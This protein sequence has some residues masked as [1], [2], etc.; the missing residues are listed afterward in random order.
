MH[1]S[2]CYRYDAAECL[3]AAQEACPL[4]IPK[5]DTPT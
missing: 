1:D 4:I 3:L 5:E 2:Q